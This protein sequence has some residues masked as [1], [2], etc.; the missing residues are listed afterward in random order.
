MHD[1]VVDAAIVIDIRCRY[2]KRESEKFDAHIHSTLQQGISGALN[3]FS[4]S[5]RAY[6]SV[7]DPVRAVTT[8]LIGGGG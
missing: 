5:V 8:A 1:Y 6:I 2:W 4:I 3:T 7:G